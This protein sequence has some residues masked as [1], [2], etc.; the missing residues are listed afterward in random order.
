MYYKHYWLSY[1]CCFESECSKADTV[2]VMT[3]V[4]TYNRDLPHAVRFLISD[5]EVRRIVYLD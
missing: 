2:S 3:T 4:F 1:V 5:I